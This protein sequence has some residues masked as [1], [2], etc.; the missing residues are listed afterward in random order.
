M[1]RT[2]YLH[3]GTH[4]TGST[5]IQQHLHANAEI[6]AKAGV[7]YP[8]ILQDISESHRFNHHNFGFALI[9]FDPGR[10]PEELDRRIRERGRKTL[11]ED[12]AKAAI[13]ELESRG[14]HEM[15]LSSEVI[16]EPFCG[17]V[18]FPEALAELKRL[19][20]G[21]TIVPVIY[22]RSQHS[23][24]ESW[25]KWNMRGGN[26][27][28]FDE[29]YRNL[30]PNWLDY[31]RLL[32]QLAET[33]GQENV[34]PRV[35]ERKE[36]KDPLFADFLETI[37]HGDVEFSPL[38]S[39]NESFSW[40]VLRYQRV[41]NEALKAHKVTRPDYFNMTVALMGWDKSL[42]VEGKRGL[43]PYSLLSRIHADFQE[44]NRK[45]AERY[46]GKTDDLFSPPVEVE[47]MDF[48]VMDKAAVKKQVNEWLSIG[49]PRQ[50]NGF[51]LESA[52]GYRRRST[53]FDEF[54]LLLEGRDGDSAV[55]FEAQLSQPLSVEDVTLGGKTQ[56]L[57][58]PAKD[59][60]PIKAEL[61]ENARIQF[62]SRP[63]AEHVRKRFCIF[64]GDRRLVENSL[65]TVAD[66]YDENL[67]PCHRLEEPGVTYV[68]LGEMLMHYGH[69]LL[70]SCART[71]ILNYVRKVR[72]TRVE[73]VFLTSAKRRN[74]VDAVL[75]LMKEIAPV[76][77]LPMGCPCFHFSRLVVPTPMFVEV[78]GYCHPA[79][80]GV[81]QRLLAPLAEHT[82]KADK[83]YLSRRKLG[84]TQRYLINEGEVEKIF[85]DHGY[86]I[87]HPQELGFAEQIG[88]YGRVRAIAG[89]E[90]S[91][92]HN[93]LLA[94]R[95]RHL[96][97]LNVHH[98]DPMVWHRQ[99]LSICLGMHL[100]T[101]VIRTHPAFEIE[102]CL[103]RK[104]PV[105]TDLAVVRQTLIGGRPDDLRDPKDNVYDKARLMPMV[106]SFFN[107]T[108]DPV[109]GEFYGRLAKGDFRSAFRYALKVP[110]KIRQVKLRGESILGRWCRST[111]VFALRKICGMRKYFCSE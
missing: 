102:D 91:A 50:F 66:G 12:A 95:C 104:V 35:F 46:F 109:N 71:W 4:K 2:L 36:L 108:E 96:T 54:R 92:I 60:P 88:L 18:A 41:V 86:E 55:A 38:E 101:T 1:S 14:L 10:M 23:W 70:E 43:F 59:I 68:F 8:S 75:K 62:R 44:P 5:T 49:K 97:I 27:A 83:I 103:I 77:M 57:E 25:Y 52:C 40:E 69:M 28:P 19:F 76:H 85:T 61:L 6:L 31:E 47:H 13:A 22:L 56:R 7:L 74:A 67:H 105:V 37:N 9:G 24:T 39:A 64:G 81:L 106:A 3:L 29:W 33:F 42:T 63:L 107:E 72:G 98:P 58:Y 32:T 48:E 11:L 65:I 30:D 110:G 78:G 100:G 17:Q 90:G 20:D 73:L 15:I 93:S 34:R 82:I 21:F 94:G 80:A 45:L 51:D 84:K 16:C 26:F 87:I 89:V 111:L 79:Y 53:F 99:Q